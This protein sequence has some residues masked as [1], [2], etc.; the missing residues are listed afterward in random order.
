LDDPD[1][2]IQL[3]AVWS[4]GEIGDN[5]AV[6]PLIAKLDRPNLGDLDAEALVNIG[7]PRTVNPLSDH[8]EKTNWEDQLQRRK[9][10]ADALAGL[11]SK[12]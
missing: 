8:L 12:K 5:R 11:T 4:L 7:D 3:G 6:G 9:R 2:S 10:V 1:F